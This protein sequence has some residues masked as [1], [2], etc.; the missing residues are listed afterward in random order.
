MFL[1][2]GYIYK[3]PL[4]VRRGRPVLFALRNILPPGQRATEEVLRRPGGLGAGGDG[5]TPVRGHLRGELKST[6]KSAIVTLT[7]HFSDA[8]KDRGDRA[9]LRSE[10]EVIFQAIEN[11]ASSKICFF[12]FPVPCLLLQNALAKV[13]RIKTTRRGFF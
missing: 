9:V 2:S 3:D 10:A 11:R 1:F 13:V 6:A 7:P 12:L 4:S 5:G 8:G